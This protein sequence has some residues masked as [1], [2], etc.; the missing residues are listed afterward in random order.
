M[1]RCSLFASSFP[2]HIQGQYWWS[3][4]W[5]TG[6]LSPLLALSS[7]S[8]PPPLTQIA[9]CCCS[10][11]GAQTRSAHPDLRLATRHCSSRSPPICLVSAAMAAIAPLPVTPADA[12]VIDRP[13]LKRVPVILLGLGGVAQALLTQIQGQ[14]RVEMHA[15]ISGV[16]EVPVV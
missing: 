8:H 7:P 14:S 12:T 6:P 2:P 15:R 10:H 16:R 3:Q 1:R 5:S 9:I 13:P 4:D 11:F